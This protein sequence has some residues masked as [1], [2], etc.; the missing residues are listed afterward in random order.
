MLS[1][2]HDDSM[3]NL[4]IKGKE[5]RK[6]AIVID[7]NKGKAFID[8][9]DQMS[10]YKPYL[11][12]IIKWYK[13]LVFHIITATTVVNAHYL[14]KKVSGKKMQIT[15]FKELLVSAM[16]ITESSPTILTPSTFTVYI[17]KEVEG[18]KRQT[19]K[20]CSLCYKQMSIS[21]GSA[22]ARKNA[23]KVNTIFEKCI[24]PI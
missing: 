9:S 7:Y 18:Q 13:R 1:T 4:N 8:L 21:K 2:K 20:R 15:K 14:Y 23:K 5:I 12:R 24:T 16:T 10:A 3:I 17:L 6:P 11:R 19:R 22:F